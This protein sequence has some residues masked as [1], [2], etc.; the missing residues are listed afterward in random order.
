[1]LTFYHRHPPGFLL[2]LVVEV[3]SDSSSGC[4]SDV[5]KG[6]PLVVTVASSFPL[7]LTSFLIITSL[8]RQIKIFRVVRL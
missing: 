7:A 5:G 8:S 1:M 3:T 6:S 2:D 4:V